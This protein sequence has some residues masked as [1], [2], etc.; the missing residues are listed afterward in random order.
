[1]GDDGIRSMGDG[2]W[3]GWG[4]GSEA[5]SFAV[6]MLAEPKRLAMAAAKSSGTSFLGGAGAGAGTSAGS[7]AV[8]MDAEPKRLA[9]AAA[10]STAPS[11]WPICAPETAC[12]VVDEKKSSSLAMVATTDE[13]KAKVV[14]LGDGVFDGSGTMND[15]SAPR[16]PACSEA[17]A[18]A[19][20]N[21]YPLRRPAQASA[22][23][24][25]NWVFSFFPTSMHTIAALVLGFLLKTEFL[26][27]AVREAR[28][29]V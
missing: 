12:A 15:V 9:M 19:P 20:P 5:G 3:D 17:Q 14:I 10:K 8:S 16:A 18:A 27:R 7:L 23:P 25:D 28:H 11:G 21:Q 13:L 2:D 1:M 6:S 4:L 26:Q 24:A 29:S 22:L